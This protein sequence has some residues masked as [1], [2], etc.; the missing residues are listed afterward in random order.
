MNDSK[1][2]RHSA[3]PPREQDVSADFGP[4]CRQNTFD[5]HGHDMHP[6][7]LVRL[8]GCHDSYHDS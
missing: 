5:A 7:K 2:P 8:V 1:L 4:M 3:E 6:Q